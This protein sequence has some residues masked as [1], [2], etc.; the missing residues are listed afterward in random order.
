MGQT[1]LWASVI[2]AVIKGDM[3]KQVE[4]PGRI[5]NSLELQMRLPRKGSAVPVSEVV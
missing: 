4:S 3:G 1:D 2:R 5:S